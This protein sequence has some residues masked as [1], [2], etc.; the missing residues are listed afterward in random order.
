MRRWMKSGASALVAV[1][2]VLGHLTFAYELSAAEAPNLRGVYNAL[3][4]VMLPVWVAQ[5]LGLFTKHGLQHSLD[6]LAATTAMQAIV[7]G[8]QEI[9]LVGNQGIDVGL[10]GADTVY[11]ASTASRFVFHMY[12]DP[13]IK[14]VADL[15]G[16]VLAAT[17]AAASTDY[18]GRILLRRYGL[19][20]DKDV[21]IVYAGSS[22]ALLTMIKSGNAAA[23]LLAAP[24]T[25]QA[26]ELG[27]K[28]ILNVTEL[29]IPFSERPGP[30]DRRG[31]RVPLP[32]TR[33]PDGPP[34]A[35]ADKP[36]GRHQGR[37]PRSFLRRMTSLAISSIAR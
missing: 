34:G 23:G 33:A 5:D 9:G 16:K 31:E 28:H 26:E 18:A 6:Y 24:V 32:G 36:G 8:T 19:V 10:E 13:G 37:L 7:G 29:N 25:F 21:K 12:G 15:K 27:L 30:G 35:R 11:I 1:L 2:T 4:G 17:Q 22:P 20:P 14:S 3:G